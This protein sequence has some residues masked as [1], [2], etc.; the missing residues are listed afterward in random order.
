MD[1]LLFTE[2]YGCINDHL[3]SIEN[4]DI[5]TL[6]DLIGWNESHPVTQFLPAFDLEFITL[7]GLSQES[8]FINPG[9]AGRQEY[10]RR[11][12]QTHGNKYG[13]YTTV[14]EEMI[15]ISGNVELVFDKHQLDVLLF[16]ARVKRG[17]CPTRVAASGGFPMVCHSVTAT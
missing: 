11:A 16:P 15:G 3:A 9:Y 2:M 1:L 8:A 12:V 7:M 6:E 14:L 17:R 13:L 4:S 10:L 5:K